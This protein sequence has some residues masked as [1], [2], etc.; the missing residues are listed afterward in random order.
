MKKHNFK[1]LKTLLRRQRQYSINQMLDKLIIE[2]ENHFKQ[3]LLCVAD[4]IFDCVFS[5]RFKESFVKTAGR[6]SP[7]SSK[8]NNILAT[9]FIFSL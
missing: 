6:F 7:E 8:R 9:S 2:F 4:G 3:P 5:A 1:W